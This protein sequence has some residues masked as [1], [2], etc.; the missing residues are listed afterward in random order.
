L[1]VKEALEFGTEFLYE[2]GAAQ[3]RLDVEVLLAAALGADRAFLFAHPEQPLSRKQEDM[4]RAWLGPRGE[5]RPLQHLLGRQEFYGRD[6]A[7]TP[8]VLIPRPET[9]LLVEASLELLRQDRGGGRALDLGTGS[10]CIAVSLACEIAGL[11]VTATDVSSAA[12]EIARRNAERYGCSGR[13]EFL[14][15]DL[16][17]P[18][19]ER[20]G[21]YDLVV[22]NPPYVAYGCPSLEPEVARYEPPEALFAGNTGLE[23]Y[24]RI[25]EQAAAVLTREG[26]LVL[27]LGFGQAGQVA[28]TGLRFGW[29][30]EELL[31]DPAGIDRCLVLGKN[32]G[33][34]PICG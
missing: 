26:R 30:I 12:L 25:L 4:L 11:Q 23:I 16:L 7:V 13:I 28:Q 2:K 17:E 1:T 19:R 9:E 5:G 33:Q 31:K 15:G 6:F 29:T 20:A 27:E 21:C 3:P 32:R 10:G 18:V 14:Q 34:S 8:A 22:S 24:D